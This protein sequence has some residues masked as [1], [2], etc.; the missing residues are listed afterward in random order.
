MNEDHANDDVEVPVELLD[1]GQEHPIIEGSQ[2]VE[3]DDDDE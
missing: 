1:P 2:Y 3:D